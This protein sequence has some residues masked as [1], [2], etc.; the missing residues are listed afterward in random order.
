MKSD[1]DKATNRM[2]HITVGVAP[3]SKFDLSLAKNRGNMD[4]HATICGVWL[5]A[6]S[7][8]IGTAMGQSS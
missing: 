3:S 4:S 7:S 8:G 1:L 5:R 6:N 2:L